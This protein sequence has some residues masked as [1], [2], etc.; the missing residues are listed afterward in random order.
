MP[1]TVILLCIITGRNILFNFCTMVLYITLRYQFFEKV[2][3]LRKPSI[4]NP[5]KLIVAVQ[6]AQV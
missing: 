5:T 4:G 3:S 6:R 1:F 2:T